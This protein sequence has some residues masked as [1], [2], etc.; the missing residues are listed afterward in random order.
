M[1]GNWPH[2]SFSGAFAPTRYQIDSRKFSAKWSVLELNRRYGNSRLRG[3]VG[4]NDRLQ[5]AT[6]IDIFQ[7]VDIYQHGDRAIKHALAFI[8]LTFLTF[9]TWEQVSKV[10]LHPLQSAV[11]ARVERILYLLLIA[12]T[13]HLSFGIADTVAAG[14][15]GAARN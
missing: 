6:G 14:G 3:E 1:T 7:S 11:R 15:A 9:F 8:T 10:R 2:S 13:Q 5:S 12:L 4:A